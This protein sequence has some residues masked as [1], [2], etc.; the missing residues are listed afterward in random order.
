MGD[1]IALPG[2]RARGSFACWLLVIASCDSSAMIVLYSTGGSFL[3]IRESAHTPLRRPPHYWCWFSKAHCVGHTFCFISRGYF[4]WFPV[5][6]SCILPCRGQIRPVIYHFGMY[7]TSTNQF[8]PHS[9]EHVLSVSY[10]ICCPCTNNRIPPSLGSP[11]PATTT[12]AG[13]SC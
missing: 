8:L 6:H 13:G 10:S 12:D 9:A 11:I 5:W 1:W 7:E 4:A 3:V 2:R